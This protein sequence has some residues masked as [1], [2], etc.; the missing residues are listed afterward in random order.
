MRRTAFTL[1]EL[2]VV[3]TII[4]LLVAI[5]MPSIGHAAYDAKSV[6]CLSAKRQVYLG[7]TGY[8]MDNSNRFPNWHRAVYIMDPGDIEWFMP[9]ALYRDYNVQPE[10]FCCTFLDKSSQDSIRNQIVSRTNADP[11]FTS[12]NPKWTLGST[13]YWVMRGKGYW[14]GRCDIVNPA[15][16]IISDQVSQQTAK[17]AIL[18]DWMVDKSWGADTKPENMLSYH[19]YHDR[20]EGIAELMGDGGARLVSSGDVKVRYNW[21]H[22]PYC[23]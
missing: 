4:A 9:A 11:K 2:L 23:W 5:V 8:A 18:T 17:D 14:S 12:G 13:A 15:Y 10:W 21:W 20:V 16:Y 22:E 7:L 6:Q 1:I 3:V 19:M